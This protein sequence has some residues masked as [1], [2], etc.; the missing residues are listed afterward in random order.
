MLIQYHN[1]I[2]QQEPKAEGKKKLV[3]HKLIYGQIKRKNQIQKSLK[4][5]LILQNLQNQYRNK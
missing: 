4:E 3:H 2:Y 5:K 1:D